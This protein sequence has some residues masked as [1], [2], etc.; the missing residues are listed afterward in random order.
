MGPIDSKPAL[1]QVM[2]W[3]RTGEKPLYEPMVAQFADVYMQQ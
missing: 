3:H 2:A 1:V